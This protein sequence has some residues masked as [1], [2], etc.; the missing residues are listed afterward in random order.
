MIRSLRL[1]SSLCSTGVHLETQQAALT[2]TADA[3]HIGLM[4][5][6]FEKRPSAVLSKKHPSTV[7]WKLH[8][9][10]C[11][12]TIAAKA[13][14]LLLKR[15]VSRVHLLCN[16]RSIHLL[17]YGSFMLSLAWTLLLKRLARICWKVMH[18]WDWC[19]LCKIK[20]ILACIIQPAKLNF[21]GCFDISVNNV[22]AIKP[23]LCKWNCLHQYRSGMQTQKGANPAT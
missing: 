5:M 8:V 6:P 23:E 7:L 12:N 19:S 2:Q 10:T 14:T 17:C 3:S 11:L 18:P 9:I 20:S 16:V 1:V 13:S 22:C 4:H 21:E 15:H